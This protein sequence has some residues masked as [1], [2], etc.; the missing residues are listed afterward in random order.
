MRRKVY[1][2]SLLKIPFYR[3]T[4]PTSCGAACLLMVG[5]FFKPEKF[6][7]TKEKEL[8]IHEKIKYWKG[9]EHGE[10]GNVAKMIKF[11]RENGFR[12]RYFLEVAPTAFIPPPDFEKELWERYMNSF[13]E[14]LAEEKERGLEVI[15][16]C[17]LELLINEILA[18]RPVIAEVNWRGYITHFVVIRGV[19]GNV[20]YLIDPLEKS[21]YRRE[22]RKWFEKDISL[23]VGK[24]FFSIFNP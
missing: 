15:E 8:E 19:K 22:H 2:K 24:N 1:P 23:K 12:V 20:I 14:V 17:T 7:L 18:G 5:H 6:P 21:G 13:F 10:F 11:M 9:D 16:N 3:Q 4:L